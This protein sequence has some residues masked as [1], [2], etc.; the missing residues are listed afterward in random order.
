LPRSAADPE[1]L[2]QELKE[3]AAKV[4]NPHL[5]RLLQYFL[6]DRVFAREMREAPAAKSMHHAYLGGLL[7]HTVSV[8]RLLERVCD[9]Y[10]ALDRDLLIAA[11]ILHDVGKMD[12]LSADMSIEYTDTGRL[13]GHVVLGAQR[14]TQKISQIR[15]FPSELALLLQH[16][17]ISHHGEYEFGAPRR[18]KTPEA[19]ALHYAD[20]LDA[21][22]NHLFRLLEAERTSPSHW[23][24]FQRAY[25]RFIYKRDG[26]DDRV[27]PERLEQADHQGEGPVNYSLL[28]QVPSGPKGEER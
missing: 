8:T 12:E 13:L 20:D 10:P 22:M 27:A 7:E 28:D 2:W 21:K 4:Q 14:V 25:D 15:G 23:T 19:F 9:H 1:A 16:L 26:G 24:T 5:T 17:I 3:L 18:P 6:T 11:G